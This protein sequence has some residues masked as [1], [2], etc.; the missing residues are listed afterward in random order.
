MITSAKSATSK[1]ARQ[2]RAIKHLASLAQDQ[3]Q[4]HVA[5]ALIAPNGWRLDLRRFWLAA[6]PINPVAILPHQPTNIFQLKSTIWAHETV[7]TKLLE[8]ARQDV[9]SERAHELLAA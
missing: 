3:S 1:L 6:Q 5:A 8:V 2:R 4:L 9:L 7:V